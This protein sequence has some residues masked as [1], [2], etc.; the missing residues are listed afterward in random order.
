[1][2]VISEKERSWVKENLDL[3]HNEMTKEQAKQWLRLMMAD[4]KKFFC[5]GIFGFVLKRKRDARQMR[6]SKEEL[7]EFCGEF[8]LKVQLA[9]RNRKVTVS[10]PLFDLVGRNVLRGLTL[11]N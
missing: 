2:A 5:L 3:R 4:Q 11:I 1:M 10:F 8:T 6:F 7:E 9:A